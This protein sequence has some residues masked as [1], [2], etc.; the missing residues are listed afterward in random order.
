MSCREV[1]TNGMKKNIVQTVSV[2]LVSFLV[3]VLLNLFLPKYIDEY[4]YSYWQTFLLYASYVPLLHF[5]FLDGLMLRYSQYDYGS[6]NKPLVRSQFKIFILSEIVLALIGFAFAQ[7]VSGLTK[8][9]LSFVSL[10]VVVL[11]LY[12]YTSY[13]FQLTNRI[14]NYAIQV[15]ILRMTLGVGIVLVVFLGSS[16][17]YQ[18][19]VVYFIAHLI[20]II[21][22]WLNNQGLFLGPSL[23]V[24][25]S[26]SEMKENVTAGATL[27]FANLSAMLLVGG[28]KLFVQWNC[29]ALVFGQVA[30][31]FN[32]LNLFL[33][34][35]TA[36]SIAIFPS[37]KRIKKDD[38]PNFYIKTRNSI[39]PFLFLALLLYFPGYYIL[40]L[41]LPNYSTSLVYLGIVMPILLFSARVSLLTNNYLKAYRKEKKMLV[42][43]AFSVLLAFGL[44]AL[45]ILYFESICLLLLCLVVVIVLHSIVSEITVMKM[46]HRKKYGT[47]ILELSIIAAY[48]AIVMKFN[49]L[50]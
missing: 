45:A 37:L 9:I 31:S 47:F 29:D 28:A 39:T 41:W 25:E 34:F 49:G 36:A 23:S 38:L 26:F 14:S 22:G 44:F 5:G 40:N 13:L 50:F 17:F 19:C 3:S 7:T 8:I 24:R 6:L 30:F 33:T 4:E 15:L 11:N 10:N 43:N 46:I 18:I 21:W 27:L 20:A 35:V 48:V 12:T 32:V 42:I 2:Q 16:R 1:E